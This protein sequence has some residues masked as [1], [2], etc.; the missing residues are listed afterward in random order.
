MR[1]V[2]QSGF[3]ADVIGGVD[4]GDGGRRQA[5][6]RGLKVTSGTLLTVNADLKTKNLVGCNSVFIVG[7]VYG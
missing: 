4:L 2:M 5:V 3:L 7:P 6:S 1:W